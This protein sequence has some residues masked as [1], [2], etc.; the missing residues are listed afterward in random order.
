MGLAWSATM[1][2][3]WPKCSRFVCSITE[4]HASVHHPE[5]FTL[6]F[7]RTFRPQGGNKYSFES[8]LSYL[9]ADLIV[10]SGLGETVDTK[11]VI[12]FFSLDTSDKLLEHLR[13]KRTL[14]CMN[15]RYMP[16]ERYR[17]FMNCVYIQAAPL[18][19]FKI[20]VLWIWF[21]NKKFNTKTIWKHRKRICDF[22]PLLCQVPQSFSLVIYI[23]L[24]V[25]VLWIFFL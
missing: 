16:W 1:C 2:P 18:N 11:R 12:N 3:K 13:K 21:G 6:N 24:D 9:L 10:L 7:K 22:V 4:C 19:S 8:L 23:Y 25:I 15:N 17:I 14:I 5:N 20:K